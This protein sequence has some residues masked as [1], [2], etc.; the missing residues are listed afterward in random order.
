MTPE[1]TK[2]F[3]Q[4]AFL[5]EEHRPLAPAESQLVI[6]ATYGAAYSAEKSLHTYHAAGP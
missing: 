2:G 5:S 4:R 6:A 1:Q 3:W